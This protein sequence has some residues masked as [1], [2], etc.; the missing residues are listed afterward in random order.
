MGCHAQVQKAETKTRGE[1]GWV[2]LGGFCLTAAGAERGMQFAPTA[3]VSAC[4]NKSRDKT[5]TVMRV[6]WAMDVK[7]RR[8]N[9]DES[10]SKNKKIAQET[11]CQ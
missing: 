6:S 1:G 10:T 4:D 2:A 3:P 7:E 9:D 5:A 11:C 8:L